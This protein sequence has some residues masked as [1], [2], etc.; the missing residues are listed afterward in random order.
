MIA[1]AAVTATLEAIENDSRSISET[2]E[3]LAQRSKVL[4]CAVR[5]RFFWGIGFARRRRRFTGLRDRKI[6][7]DVTRSEGVR[8]LPPVVLST[9]IH[10]F[11]K[12]VAV[13]LDFE[14][15]VPALSVWCAQVSDLR[16]ATLFSWLDRILTA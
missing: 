10:L 8:L 14:G 11:V 9:S 7:T 3:R 5:G 6:I 2:A 4:R 16:R 12:P 15:M 13:A 1:M